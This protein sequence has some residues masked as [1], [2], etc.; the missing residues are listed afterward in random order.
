[1]AVRVLIMAGGTGGHV[2]PALAVADRLR[3]WGAEVVWMGTRHGLEAELVPK[4]GYPIE[5]ISVSG[6]RGK[7]LTHW[8][9]APFKLLLALS[10]A[11][12]A[13]RRWQPAVVLGLGGFVAGPGGLGAWLLR[14][15]LLIHEQNAIVGTANRLLA[16]LASRVMEAFPGAFPPARKAEWTG[17]PVRESIEQLSETG[18]R[19]QARQGRLRLLVFGGS[20]GAQVLNA[21]VPQALALLPAKVRPQVWHQ[22]GSRQWEEAVAAYR[23]V[24]VE[25]RLV[26][27]IDDMAAAYA[28][29][30]LVVCRAGALTVAELM[31]VGVG[32]LLVPFPLAIDDHQRAN[33]EYLVA[34]GAALLLPEKE[35]SSSRLAQA[36]EHLVANRSILISM[37]QAARQLHRAGAARRVAERCLEAA[38]G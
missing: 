19:L 32:A 6:L 5:W 20:Q 34:A 27:F 24:G 3:A 11:L 18:V 16:P 21:T 23:A 9:R 30:D 22:C 29:A 13:Q 38:D 10:Q 37:A 2:F 28:W 33:A 26:P 36:I 14:R 35:L 7:G 17:N 1:M 12:R 8:L 4:A 25:A 15:P 31:A